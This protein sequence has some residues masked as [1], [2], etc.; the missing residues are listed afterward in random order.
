MGKV[1]GTIT[2]YQGTEHRYLRNH[3]IKVVA[4]FKGAASPDYDPDAGYE[5]ATSDEALARMGRLD[6]NDRVEVV[7]WIESAGRWSFASSDPRA[8]DLAAF[9]VVR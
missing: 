9:D 8:V 1:I 5:V 4:V 2:T 7:P 3:Q 6:V